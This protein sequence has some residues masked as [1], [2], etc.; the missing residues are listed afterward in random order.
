MRKKIKVSDLRIGMYVDK[1]EGNW[2][3][4][5]FWRS[6]FNNIETKDLQAIKKSGIKEV[7]IDTSKGPDVEDKTT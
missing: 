4:H 6:A 5:P 1:L 2:L 3:Q 7:W